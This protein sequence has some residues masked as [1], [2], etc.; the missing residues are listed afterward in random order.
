VE[1][2]ATNG[3]AVQARFARM[4]SLAVSVDEIF[5]E[6]AQHLLDAFIADPSDV[7]SLGLQAAPGEYTKR[8]LFGDGMTSVW[9]FAWGPGARTPIHDHHCPCVVGVVDGSIVEEWFEPTNEASDFV[10]LAKSHVRL[11]GA[12]TALRPRRPNI[13]RIRNEGSEMAITAHIY[14]FNYKAVTTS[15]D[16]EYRMK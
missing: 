15:V 6:K 11:Q 14:G 5:I 9:V 16:R 3:D 12:V 1:S 7:L 13:H 2:T 4:S 8:F 10:R